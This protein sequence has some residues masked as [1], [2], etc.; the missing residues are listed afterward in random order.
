MTTKIYEVPRPVLELALP[1]IDSAA[2]D[3]DCLLLPPDRKTPRVLWGQTSWLLRTVHYA[4]ATSEVI[5]IEHDNV[6]YATASCHNARCIAIA[7][8]RLHQRPRERQ[9]GGPPV[10]EYC[11]KGLH[12]LAETQIML[13]THKRTCGVCYKDAAAIREQ[14]ES[15]D[16]AAKAE[17]YLQSVIH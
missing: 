17:S 14:K 6:L 12:R 9:G 16:W 13:S 8:T 15:G 11:R 2:W 10:Q 1:I 4:I 7:H 5:E 3:K